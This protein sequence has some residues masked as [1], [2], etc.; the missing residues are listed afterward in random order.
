MLF[1]IFPDCSRDNFSKGIPTGSPK[2][3]VDHIGL[4][5]KAI[6]F[7]FEEFSILDEKLI[8]MTYFLQ[9]GQIFYIKKKDLL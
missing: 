7:V 5:L 8:V 2:F 6:E 9:L 4:C 1:Q 3:N